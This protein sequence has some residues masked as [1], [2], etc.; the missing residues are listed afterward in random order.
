MTIITK[1]IYKCSGKPRKSKE[2][3]VEESSEVE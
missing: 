3:A 1:L 2:D